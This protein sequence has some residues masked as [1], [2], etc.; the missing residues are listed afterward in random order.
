MLLDNPVIEVMSAYP[1]N[2]QPGQL[3]ILQDRGLRYFDEGRWKS[4]H[5]DFDFAALV[6]F[7]GTS[8]D[9]NP[10]TKMTVR[11]ILLVNTSEQDITVSVRLNTVKLLN[12]ASVQVGQ[13]LQMDV[14]IPMLAADHLHITASD[15]ISCSLI[16]SDA[17]DYELI[18]AGQNL[19]FVSTWTSVVTAMVLC[20]VGEEPTTVTVKFCFNG[21]DS[22]S[23]IFLKDLPLGVGESLFGDIKHV[24]PTGGRL[25][26]EGANIHALF[27]GGVYG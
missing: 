26:V 25:I 8:Y 20:N 23:A 1:A 14:A 16:G 3:I 12:E 19:N 2:S 22:E 5:N 18:A 7:S 6:Q 21:V 10:A 9:Y 13:T 17:D 4:G 24:L 27:S 15:Q 11:S